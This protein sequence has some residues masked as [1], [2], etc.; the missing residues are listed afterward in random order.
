MQNKELT[1]LFEDIINKIIRQIRDLSNENFEAG[2][3]DSTTSNCEYLFGTYEE[4]LSCMETLDYKVEREVNK[5]KWNFVQLTDLYTDLVH[6]KMPNDL[7]LD[8]ED[9]KWL[10]ILLKNFTDDVEN[11]LK[12]LR[13]N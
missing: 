6:W 10:R 5:E 11:L 12:S 4:L 9:Q 3:V 13:S 2:I 7:E 1:L 8:E